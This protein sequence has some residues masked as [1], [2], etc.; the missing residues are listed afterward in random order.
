[1]DPDRNHVKKLGLYHYQQLN[2]IRTKSIAEILVLKI[3]DYFCLKVMK[4][5]VVLEP[6]H[7][8]KFRYVISHM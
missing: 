3:S 4:D 2:F 8:A 5:S 7:F 1:M 6:H